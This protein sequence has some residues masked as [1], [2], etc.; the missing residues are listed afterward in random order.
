VSTGTA[1]AAAACSAVKLDWKT[2][3][4]VDVCQVMMTQQ[5]SQPRYPRTPR[6]RCS[7]PWL[8][9]AAHS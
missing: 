3:R 2:R 4:D 6:H 1:A 9:R 8:A 7:A 5:R